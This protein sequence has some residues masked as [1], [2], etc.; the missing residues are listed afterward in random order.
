MEALTAFS[1]PYTHSGVWH[2]ER[3]PANAN[4]MDACGGHQAFKKKKQQSA[5]QFDSN[6]LD[7]V[8]S[9]F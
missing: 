1:N 8:D 7:R 2:G 9:I 4:T 3:I 6:K 5:V